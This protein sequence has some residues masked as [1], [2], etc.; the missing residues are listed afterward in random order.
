MRHGLVKVSNRITE[1]PQR[2]RRAHGQ[3][4]HIE[5]MKTKQR[6]SLIFPLVNIWNK[7]KNETVE[8]TDLLTFK[9]AL[10]KENLTEYA[11]YK[12]CFC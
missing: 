2:N 10:L 3:Q 9:K 12:D 6:Q 11:L 4:L 8:S 7:L 5:V 1:M